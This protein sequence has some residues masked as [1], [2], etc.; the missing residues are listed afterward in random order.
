MQVSVF[1][2]TYV[3]S[4]NK[5]IEAAEMQLVTEVVVAVLVL[6]AA[7]LCGTLVVALRRYVALR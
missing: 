3:A 6:C 5:A 4:V 2:S 7:L 1:D